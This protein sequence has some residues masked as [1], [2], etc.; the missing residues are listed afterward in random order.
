MSPEGREIDELK[1]A[2]VI[3]EKFNIA[4]KRLDKYPEN[5]RHEAAALIKQ[6]WHFILDPFVLL[7]KNEELT[8]LFLNGMKNLDRKH[9][10]KKIT[11]LF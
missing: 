4:F 1:D 11:V 6:Y 10:L 2:G 7:V 9:Y 8:H 3:E 5:F